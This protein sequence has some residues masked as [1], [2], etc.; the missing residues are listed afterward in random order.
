MRSLDDVIFVE[1][2]RNP[3]FISD[4]I[5]PNVVARLQN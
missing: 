3:N 1:F 2:D 5:L 4:D